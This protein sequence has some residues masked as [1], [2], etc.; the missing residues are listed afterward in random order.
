MAKRRPKKKG[1]KPNRRKKK[2]ETVELIYTEFEITDEPIYDVHFKRLPESVKERI[3][4]LR[5]STFNEP[6]ATIDELLEMIEKYPKVTVF[7]NYLVNAYALTD[8]IEKAHERIECMYETFPNYLFAKIQYAHMRYEQTGTYDALPE[9]FNNKYDLSLLYPRKKR[10]HIS[11]VMSFYSLMGVYRHFVG[12]EEMA[13][14]YLEILMQLDPTHRQ[15]QR[16]FH[17]LHD[18]VFEGLMRYFSNE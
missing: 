12:D 8:Q 7:H 14:K 3:D 18:N 2:Q 13:E 4:G 17:T 10:F 16:L 6:E 11:E 15:T 9:I 1:P 5:D